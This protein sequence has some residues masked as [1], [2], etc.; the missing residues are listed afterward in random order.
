MT[1]DGSLTVHP[2]HLHGIHLN[3]GDSNGF[4]GIL[5]LGICLAQLV[6]RLPYIS[7]YAIYQKCA[8]VDTLAL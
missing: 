6:L 5:S 1:I 8:R 4:L 2:Y 3:G 7:I